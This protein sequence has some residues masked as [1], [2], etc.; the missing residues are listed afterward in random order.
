MR[1]ETALG[2][3][4]VIHH[5]DS[6][7][8]WISTSA[9]PIRGPDGRLL[10]A[11]ATYGDV[12]RQHELQQEREDLLHTVSHDLRTPLTVIQG[13]AQMLLRT[14]AMADV[15]ASAQRSAEAILAGSRRMNT[16]IQDLVD[17][18]RL[19]SGQMRLDR[20]PVDLHRLLLEMKERLD[21][22]LDTQ[23]IRAEASKELPPVSADPNRLERILT[24]LL[25]NALKYSSPGTEIVV[26]IT[27]RDG[28]VITSVTDQGPGIPPEELPRLFQRFRRTVLA[29]ERREG[30]GLG[31]YITRR[32]VEAHG[33]RIW[34]E[35]EVGKGSCFSFTLPVE[36][37]W[38]PCTAG[39]AG[40]P[41]NADRTGS[42]T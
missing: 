6:S 13:Q 28:Q 32:L 40:S 11:V 14:L 19:E 23:R 2:T 8:L 30:L 17:S 37:T 21:G 7:P 26:S 15:G 10:G 25:S 9:A 22:V 1:G 31:L 24:N 5:R 38:E 20:E 29:R 4:A 33:G 16:M 18:A 34:V 12:T 27:H 39:R 41:C 36:R 42:G 3:V 35:S